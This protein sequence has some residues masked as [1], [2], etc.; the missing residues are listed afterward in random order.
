MEEKRILEIIKLAQQAKEHAYAPYSGFRVG[1]C[2]AA[3]NGRL[4]TGCNIENAS[5]GATVCAERTAVFKAISEG[6]NE[7]E[8]IALASDATRFIL[9]C[10][11][12]RQVLSEF[13]L[14]IL[15]ISSA[16]SNEYKIFSLEELLPGAFS[17][18]DLEL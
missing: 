15:V 6:E 7:F 13:S 11:I 1:A 4:Y 9:P 18:E 5:Y 17:G 12:C 8:A 16:N 3:K 10:G 14:N 2:I